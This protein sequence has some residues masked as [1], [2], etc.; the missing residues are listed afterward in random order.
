M[1][2]P[3]TPLVKGAVS[4]EGAATPRRAGTLARALILAGSAALASCE[5]V[6]VTSVEVA[7]IRVEPA[8][9]ILSAG[10][11]LRLAATPVDASGNPLRDRPVVWTSQDTAVA[12]VDHTGLV[13]AR[14]E[15]GAVVRASAGG[16]QGA[17]SIVVP[18]PPRVNPELSEVVAEPSSLPVGG[19]SGSVVTVRLR[20]D[21]GGLITDSLMVTLRIASGPGGL[22]T[23]TPPFDAATSSYS[24]E[25]TST[26]AGETV[27]AAA[28][29]GGT[30]IAQAALVEFR[31]GPA[32]NIAVTA[33]QGQTGPA[34]EPLPDSLEVEVTDTFGNP[35]AG[36]QVTWSPGAGSAAP[37]ASETRADG[38][39]RTSWTMGPVAGE[40]TLGAAAEG[41]ADG[42]TF[43]A[44]TGVGG[45]SA[46]ESSVV[47]DPAAVAADGEEAATISVTLRDAQ[48]N[49]I[50][51]ERTVALSITSGPGT[52]GATSPPYD[53][54]TST[55]VTTVT[56]SSGGTA[57]IRAVA[58]G[59]TLEEEPTV[60]FILGDVSPGTS[61]A[62]AEPETVTADGDAASLITV[63]LRDAEGSL[64]TDPLPVTLLIASGPGELSTGSPAFDSGTDSYSATLTSTESG[65]TTIVVVADAVTLNDRPQVGFVAGPVSSVE[66]S[67]AADPT[68]VTSDGSDS[69][70]LTVTLRDAHRN[71]ITTEQGVSLAV[72]SGPGAVGGVDFDPGTS[73]YSASLAS[74]TP[75]TATV[76]AEANGVAIAQQSVVEFVIGGVSAV[77]STVT[78]DPATVPADGTT[79]S[80]VTVE[81]RD[82]GG[83]AIGGRTAGFSVAL[84]GTAT[85]TAVNETAA[86]GTYQFGVT[87]AATETVTVTVTVDGVT[88][89]DQPTVAFVPGAA[90]EMVIVSGNNQTGPKS[91][92]LADPLQVR[93]S[94]ASG[95]PVEGVQVTWTAG[96]ASGAASPQTSLS[97]AEGLATTV[98]TLGTRTGDQTL[99]ATAVGVDDPV[100]FSATAEAGAVS[101]TTST[102]TVDPA[103]VPADGTTPSTLTVELRD[104]EGDAIGG[105]TDDDF[106]VTLTG[107]AVA[108]TVSETETAGTYQ[109]GLTNTTPETV[110]VTVAVDGVTLAD[111]PTVD[112]TAGPAAQILVESG[113]D[114]TGTAGEALA[115]PLQVRVSDASGNPVAGVE[116]TWTAAEGS[117]GANPQTSVSSPEGLATTVWTLGPG[118][119][120]QTLEATAAGVAEPVTFS[121]TAEPG[122][123]SA[124]TSTVTAEPTTVPADGI[125]ASTV[126]V[127]LRDGNGN[128][129]GGRTGDDF[130]VTLAGTAVATAVTETGTPG[131]YQFGLTS[132]ATQTVTVTVTADEVTLADQPT[133]AFVAGAPAQIVLVSGSNQT[134]TAGEALADPLEVRV[135]DGSSHPVEGVEVTWAAAGGSG[136]ANPP[137]S[138]SSTEGVATTA[139]TLGPGTGDQSL[140][141]AAAGVAGSVTFSATAEAGPVS[142]ETSTVTAEPATVPADGT[143]AS[144]VTVELR[145]G[146]GNALGGRTDGFSVALT[147][148]AVP[149]AVS[150]TATAGTYQFGVTN[151]TPQTVTVTVTVDGVTLADEPTVD[152][153]AGTPAEAVVMTA[154]P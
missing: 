45:V 89:A 118:A 137:T 120:P 127:E 91:E 64:L 146:N 83:N 20:D 22:S 108:T 53:P 148:T 154:F 10:D 104:G 52:L 130:S 66:S 117:G 145:D 93:I 26:T 32:A 35:V 143:T 98:W 16:V 4:A 47:A 114:Q 18:E 74:S 27:V 88:L 55:Y 142:A 71:L 34:G 153:V 28:D 125:T 63:T 48:G 46:S 75:G 11:T 54:G 17:A 58:D 31:A 135:S 38:R 37:A 41:V 105:R 141:A 1:L 73:T 149:T 140:E 85:A 65:T 136:A 33:G 14:R 121:A 8:E 134:G 60:Q 40:Q 138:V 82:G 19:S 107:T 126:T 151:T 111:E 2:R 131:T 12:V 43:T 112:F 56:S 86:A 39:A 69:S 3:A 102:V 150:E 9:A 97:S 36:V 67:L 128:A 15:G 110:T 103:T 78:A 84:T 30:A 115:D 123:V 42:V 29:E 59:V 21:Q 80:T 72:V 109:S 100:T 113:N 144:T 90:T 50:P 51:E 92:A 76:Q 49:L 61:T 13:T 106:S 81:L 57:V 77:A 62:V 68:Q 5:Q 24:A 119:V 6:S 101:A 116:V 94:D 147:G 139:W 23:T 44:T 96:E 95:H 87:N 79:A 99:A 25:V 124:T 70:T 152:F 133:V 122:A 132:I 129:L 7:A